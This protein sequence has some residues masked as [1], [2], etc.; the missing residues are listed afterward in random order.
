MLRVPQMSEVTGGGGKS[1]VYTE[2]LVVTLYTMR[3]AS[4]LRS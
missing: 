2:I 3:Q 4:A 1:R